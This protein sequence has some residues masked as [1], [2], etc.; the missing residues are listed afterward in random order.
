MQLWKI[1]VAKTYFDIEVVNFKK[2]K[3]QSPGITTDTVMLW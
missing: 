1:L 3:F 2:I